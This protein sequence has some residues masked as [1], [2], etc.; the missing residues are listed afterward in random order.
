MSGEA[1]LLLTEAIRQ[2]STELLFL[3]V[4]YHFS[5][6]VVALVFS[7]DLLIIVLTIIVQRLAARHLTINPMGRRLGYR[8]YYTKRQ[9]HEI[10]RVFRQGIR[11]TQNEQTAARTPGERR[12][13]P[14]W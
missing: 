1:L 3:L 2:L 14:E 11:L 5:K 8:P 7:L 6:F 9:L 10:Q 4:H 12:F 13:G